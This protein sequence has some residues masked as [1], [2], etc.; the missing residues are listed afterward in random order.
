MKETRGMEISSDNIHELGWKRPGPGTLTA[1]PQVKA[2]KIEESVRAEVSKDKVK[3]RT[4][5]VIAKDHPSEW[6]TEIAADRRPRLGY[7]DALAQALDADILYPDDAQETLLGRLIARLF[8]KRPALAW[9]AF[10]RHH[11]YDVLYTDIEI[12]GLPL[13]MLLKLSGTRPEHPRHVTRS[14]Y[15]SP[16]KK[17][18]FFMLRA[19]SHIDTV[20]VHSAAQYAFVTEVLHVPHERVV[21]LP[22]FVDDHFWRPQASATSDATV[23]AGVMQRPMIYAPG[24]EFRDYP[25][26]FKAV[27]GLNVD[28]R[29]TARDLMDFSNVHHTHMVPINSQMPSTVSIG[30]YDY[31]TVRQIYAASRFVVVPLREVSYQAGIIVILEAMAMGKAVILSG[32]RGQTDV[33]RDYRNSGHGPVAREWWPGFADAP[34]NTGETLGHLPTGLYVTP[35][36]PDDLHHAIQYLLDHPEKAEEMGQNGRRVAEAYFGLDGFVQRLAA[37][38]RG[39]SLIR[40]MH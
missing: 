12:V 26:L 32:I 37:T 39:E 38:I 2:S 8:R 16:L 31:V 35:G 6:Q 14:P 17:R 11:A 21:K 7:D 30:S 4:L 10:R 18:I 22:Y 28:V 23:I 20:M 1:G 36:D 5:L 29:I 19:G 33:I 27:D 25:T 3:P 15:P 40:D 24:V 13:A 34:S 9:A